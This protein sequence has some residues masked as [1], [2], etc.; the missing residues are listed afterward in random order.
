LESPLG[1]RQTNLAL[2]ALSELNQIIEVPEE[3]IKRPEEAKLVQN[4]TEKSLEPYVGS[5]VDDGIK[6]QVNRRSQSSDKIGPLQELVDK[7]KQMLEDMTT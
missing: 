4:P 5:S 2:D 3:N 1:V 7:Q 6:S